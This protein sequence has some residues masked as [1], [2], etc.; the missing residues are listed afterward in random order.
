MP[1]YEYKC[2]QCQ[3][4]F[5]HLKFSSQDPEPRCPSCCATNVQRLISAGAV[6]PEGIPKGKGGFT[7]PKCRPSGG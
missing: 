7:P 6:R 3:C 1:I 5:E 2:L 4:E